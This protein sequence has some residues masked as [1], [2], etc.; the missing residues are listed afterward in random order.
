MAR[1]CADFEQLR[2]R[3]VTDGVYSSKDSRGPRA[4]LPPRFNFVQVRHSFLLP[5]VR[6]DA[7][8]VPFAILQVVDSA[9]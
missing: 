6:S 1:D 9:M 4:V 8:R 2:A 3:Q 7:A 5:P